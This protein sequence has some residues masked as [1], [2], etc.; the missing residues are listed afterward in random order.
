MVRRF[1]KEERLFTSRH[2]RQPRGTLCFRPRQ[3]A[4]EG[5]P[6]RVKPRGNERRQRRVGPRQGN[7]ANP[8]GNGLPRQEAPRVRNARQPGVADAGDERPLL[9][10]FNER[11]ALRLLIMLVVAGERRMNIKMRQKPPGMARIL[12]GDQIDF[13]EDAH[14]P[15]RH[16]FQIADRRS[17]QIKGAACR[18]PFFHSLLF[19]HSFSPSP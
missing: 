14:R 8:G 10:L 19:Y 7:D 1:V 18:R 16:I 17:A 12:G 3:K 5:E 15:I 4:D 9:E 13:F 2:F 6:R 11:R